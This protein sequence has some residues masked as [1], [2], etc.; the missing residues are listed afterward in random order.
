SENAEFAARCAAAGL[1]FIGP[2]SEVLALF[3]DKISARR[4][5]ESLAVPVVPGTISATSL[6]EARAFAR[7]H[8]AVMLKAMSGGGG[9]GM[10]AVHA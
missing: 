6:G 9:R 5:A 8:G 3:G 2:S 10:R 7:D 4:L 1:T